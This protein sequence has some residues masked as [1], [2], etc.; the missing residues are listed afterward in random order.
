RDRTNGGFSIDVTSQRGKRISGFLKNGLWFGCSDEMG[1]KLIA[2]EDLRSDRRYRADL[3]CKIQRVQDP[4][5]V[6][7]VR[8]EPSIKAVIYKIDFYNVGGAILRSIEE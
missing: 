2:D 7:I 1:R 5:G 8:S 3:Y 4:R 6:V